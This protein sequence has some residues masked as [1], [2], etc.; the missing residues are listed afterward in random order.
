MSV[1]AVRTAHTPVR[2][3]LGWP[4]CSWPSQ[5]GQGQEGMGI[6]FFVSS[7]DGFECVHVSALQ[8]VLLI[9]SLSLSPVLTDFDPCSSFLWIQRL[10]QCCLGTQLLVSAVVLRWHTLNFSPRLA[11]PLLATSVVTQN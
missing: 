7:P 9:S 2:K 10:P 11:A 4:S 5:L 1:A 8:E 6:F 3:L